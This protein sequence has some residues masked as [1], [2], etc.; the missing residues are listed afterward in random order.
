MN[1]QPAGSARGA[2]LL[3]ISITLVWGLSWPANKVALAEITPWVYRTLNLNIGGLGLLALAWASGASLRIPRREL[4]PLL[5]ASFFNF[6][7]W[8]I[9]SAYGIALL[10]AGRAV[11]IAFTMPAW[12]ALFD[13]FLMGERLTWRRCL[14]LTLGLGGLAVLMG[15]DI[16]KLDAAPWGALAMLAAA[17]GWG[18]GTVLMKKYSWT[19]PTLTL[20]GWQLILGGLPITAGSFLMEPWTGL[21]GA[22]WPAWAATAFIIAMSMIYAYWAWFTVLGRISAALAAISTM[23]IPVVGV[24]TSALWLGEK[25]GLQELLALGMVLSS[26]GVVFLDSGRLGRR[27]P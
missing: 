19:M 18:M 2:I 11:I 3:M 26:M 10:P 20:T 7:V 13:F 9:G 21:A 12:A 15:P 22:S 17:G 24:F 27:R 14:G 1:P 16:K 8:H 25:L 23:V 4:R 6:T 5:L